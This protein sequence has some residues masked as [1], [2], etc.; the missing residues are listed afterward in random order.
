MLSLLVKSLLGLRYR[1]TVNGLDRINH[2]RGVLVLPN[3][4]AEIDPVIVTTTLWDLLHP[5]PVVIEGMYN[6]P[7]L[8]PIMK[9]IRAIPMADMEFDSGPYKRRRIQ[10]TLDEIVYALQSGDNILLYPS[11]RLSVTGLERIGGASGVHSI[12]KGYPNAHIAVVKIR[13]LYGSI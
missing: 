3:H 4:P 6:L 11:G 5:R 13:G 10:R 12:L 1:V 2:K 9:R 7:L 8:N